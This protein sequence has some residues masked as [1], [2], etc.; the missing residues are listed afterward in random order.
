MPEGDSSG[1]ITSLTAIKDRVIEAAALRFLLWGTTSEP[2]A[3]ILLPNCRTPGGTGEVMASW[4]CEKGPINMGLVGMIRNENA[5]HQANFKTGALN[6]SATLPSLELRGLAI[7]WRR[8]KPPIDRR[9][10]NK[11]DRP[12]PAFRLFQR[13]KLREQL[14]SFYSRTWMTISVVA[15]IC[16]AG[17]IV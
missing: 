15:E 10:A 16:S 6:H 1:G 7:G 9:C 5:H 13:V 3:T 12:T 14:G 8:R 2:P 17:R 4:R 11:K